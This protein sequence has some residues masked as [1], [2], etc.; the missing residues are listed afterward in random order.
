MTRQRSS[1]LVRGTASIA[2]VATV[3]CLLAGWASAA[4]AAD[5]TAPPETIVLKAA[6]VFDSTGTTLKDGGI[7]VARGDRIV[8]VGGTGASSFD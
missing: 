8:S 2:A 1:Q 4:A 3:A 5:A 7:V 6:H